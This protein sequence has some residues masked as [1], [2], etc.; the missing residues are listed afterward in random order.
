VA[1]KKKSLGRDPFDDRKQQLRSGS[2]ERLIKGKGLPGGA[3]GAREVPVNVKLTPANLK[4]LDTI[5]AKL[6]EQGK[7]SYT[8][9]DLIR[10]AIALLSVEDI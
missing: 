10:I 2:V 3:G 7:G 6:A 5:R 8:R 1:K 9:S 4:H